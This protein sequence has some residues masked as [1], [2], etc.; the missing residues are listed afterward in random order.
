MA[1]RTVDVVAAP[2][3]RL[4]ADIWDGQGTPVVLLHGL[5]QQRHFW[6]PVVRRLRSRPVAALD[7]RAH[8]D[9]DSPLGTDV[10][11]PA[12]ADD[13]ARLLDACGWPR[14]VIVGHSWGAAIALAAA[15]AHPERTTAAVLVDGGLLSPGA[16]GDRATVRERLRPPVLDLPESE[17]WERISSGALAPMWSDETRA[18]LAPTFVRDAGGRMRTRIG[19]DRHMAVLDGL[20]DHDAA[21]DLSRTEAAGVPVWAAV[22]EPAGLPATPADPWVTVREDA[23]A[24][25]TART[26]CRIH[27]WAGA[28]HDVPLQWPALVA[29]LVD[30]VVECGEGS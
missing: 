25:A 2:G 27:R 14:A 26:N 1:P 13:V 4:V 19:V 6:R 28:V 20:L 17:L 24:A 11:I 5:S 21:R 18:A 7:Q 3:V 22:C 8:G 23:I 9:T 12:C 15:A 29:G 10:S 30:A 16:V